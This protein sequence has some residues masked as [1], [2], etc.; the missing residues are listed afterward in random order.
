M[1][2]QIYIIIFLAFVSVLVYL[3]LELVKPLPQVG[4]V[5]GTVSYG[6]DVA[7]V[8]MTLEQDG[9]VVASILTDASGAYQFQDAVAIGDYY[10]RAHKDV[11][12][13]FLT[14]EAMVTVIGGENVVGD[15]PL[16]K[17]NVFWDTLIRL[18]Y[19]WHKQLCRN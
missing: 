8:T 9:I 5:K 15:L 13:G 6:G 14:A 1:I 10:L 4:T 11:P 19:G 16:V 12:E 18:W 2:D 17:S 7:G 3:I